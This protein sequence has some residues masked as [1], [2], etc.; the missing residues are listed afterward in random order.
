MQSRIL[1]GRIQTLHGKFAR[2]TITAGSSGHRCLCQSSFRQ[3]G[4][5]IGKGHDVFNGHTGD[6]GKRLVC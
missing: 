5:A 4:L 1:F 3:E 2:K 6:F